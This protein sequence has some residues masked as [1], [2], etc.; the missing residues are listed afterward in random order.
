MASIRGV[1]CPSYVLIANCD[2]AKKKK[3]TNNAQ[4]NPLYFK[5]DAYVTQNATPAVRH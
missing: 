1:K 4:Q 3:V 5:T 2:L